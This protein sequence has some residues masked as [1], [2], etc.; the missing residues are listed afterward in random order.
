MNISPV[1]HNVS[2]L[3]VIKAQQSLNK[4]SFPVHQGAPTAILVAANVAPIPTSNKLMGY[5]VSQ[6]QSI[7]RP[8]PVRQQV[9]MPDSI[10]TMVDM[11][12]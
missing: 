10:G 11:L 9:S 6:L 1:F 8:A 3:R 4:T 7:D 12:V 5:S 2:I